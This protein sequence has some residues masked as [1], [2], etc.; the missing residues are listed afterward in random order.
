MKKLALLCAVSTACAATSAHAQSGPFVDG[1][2]AIAEDTTLDVIVDG[3]LRYETVSQPDLPVR[4]ADALTFRIRSGAELVSHGFFVLGETEATL[5]IIDDYNDTIPGNGIEPYSVVPDPENVE[6][7]RLQVG[8][9]SKAGTLTVG[10]QRIIHDDHRFVGNVG[11]RQNEQT[12]DAVRAQGN[13]GPAALDATYAISQ[14]TIFG[15]DSPNS[16]FDG[17]MILLN[18]GIDVK[19]AQVKAFAYL[20]DYDD[21]KPARLVYSSQ[22]YG[23]RAMGTVPI[24]ETFKLDYLAS[25]ARQSDY[26]NNPTSYSADYIN[27]EAGFAIGPVAL[28]GGYELLGSDDGVAAFQTPLATLHKFNGFADLFLSTPANGLQDYYGTAG[29]KLGDVAVM[30]GLAANVTYHQ[31]DSDVG[32]IDYGSEWDAVVSFKVGKIGV[33]AKYANYQAGN[34][35]TDTEKFWL[36]AGFSF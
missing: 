4:D 32:G 3:M 26:G 27:G 22:S 20:L 18:G 24:G 29:I 17:D 9:K 2:I 5:A 19:I 14:R 10:R 25:Y 13:I 8:Y 6:V 12:F 30:K 34:F 23:F 1:P 35:G 33:L 11:W 31:F 21:E 16:H 15:I 7:N 36:Q 28:R